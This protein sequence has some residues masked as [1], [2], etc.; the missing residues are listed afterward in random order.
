MA[1]VPNQFSVEREKFKQCLQSDSVENARRALLYPLF[2]KLFKEKFKIENDAAG[3]DVYI[4]GQLIVESKTEFKQ[5]L[6]G[7]FQALHYHRKAGLG[8]HTIMVVAKEF[9]GIWKVNKLP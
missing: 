5:W 4:V 3:A 2:Q 9:V 1:A 8:F 7:L 6:D